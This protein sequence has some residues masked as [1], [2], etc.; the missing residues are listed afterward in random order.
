MDPATKLKLEKN[1]ERNSKFLRRAS[2]LFSSLK[3][4]GTDRDSAGNRRLFFNEYCSW[5]LFYAMTPMLESMRALQ[6]A[7]DLRCLQ[8]ALGLR[9]FSLG[10]FSE[11]TAVFDADLLEPIVANVAVQLQAKA[12]DPRLKKLWYTVQLVDSTLLRTLPQILGTFSRHSRDGEPYHAWRVHMELQ[13]G[14]PAPEHFTLTPAKGRERQVLQRQLRGG[15][16]YVTDRGYQSVALANAIHAAGSRYVC[17][18]RHDLVYSVV[19]DLELSAEDR[20]AGVLS[21]QIVLIAQGRKQRPDHIV[22]LVTL[23]AEVHPKRVAR[24][25]GTK[26]LSPGKLLVLTDVSQEQASAAVVGLLYQYRWSIEVFFRVFKQVLGMRHL[27]GHREEAVR[28]QVCCTVLCCVLLELWTG[29]K[30]DLPT[31]R[32]MQW[33]V[34]GVA[35]LEEV[36]AFVA[37]RKKAKSETTA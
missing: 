16:C 20:A 10:S 12:A 5:V 9:R 8:Q 17:R 13:I 29:Q 22:R 1:P 33:Y 14:L 7:S 23:K 11:A 2:A 37:R 3:H 32:M 35:T 24:K 15:C 25:P 31:V 27:L 28:I 36:Q 19:K 6:E 4:A 26:T 21:E 34:L 18:V 30:A